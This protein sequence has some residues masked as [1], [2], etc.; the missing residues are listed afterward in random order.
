MTPDDIR[1][2]VEEENQHNYLRDGQVRAA[3]R[4]SIKTEEDTE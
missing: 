1:D 3:A 2:L 4:I